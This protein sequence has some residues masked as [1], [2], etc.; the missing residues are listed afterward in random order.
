MPAELA[1]I[2]GYQRLVSEAFI[3]CMVRLHSI[4]V[5]QPGLASLGKPAGFVER[6]VKGWTERWSRAKTEEL[7]EMELVVQ[8]LHHRLPPDSGAATLVHNDYKLDNVMM[9]PAGN[10]VEAVL[11]WEMTTLGD[12]LS[13]LGL[14]MCYWTWASEAAK[15]D[16]HP[17]TPVITN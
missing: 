3:D 10:R 4:D 17:A 6:Q 15:D 8:W 13:D 11:D 1:G 7:P 16:P 9:Q 14:T 5:T 12:P 2:P